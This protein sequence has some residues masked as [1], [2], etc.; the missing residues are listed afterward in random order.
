MYL[1]GCTALGASILI[2]RRL[3]ID[4]AAN[5]ALTAKIGSSTRSL[6]TSSVS[7]GY[8]LNSGK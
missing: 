5:Y 1:G 3:F 7:I 8:L 6:I 4:V 2:T